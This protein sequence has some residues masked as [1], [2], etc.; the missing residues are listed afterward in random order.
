M[1]P[2]RTRRQHHPLVVEAGHQHVD[3]VADGAEHVLLR[4]LAIRKHQLGGVGAAHAELVELLRGRKTLEALFDDE[5][6]D[7]AGAGG[8]VG[9][10]VDHQRVGE[11]AVGDP[12][13]GAVENVAVALLV[14]AGAHRHHVGA[15][16]RLRHRQ[17]ADVFA[18]DQLG[19]VFALLGLGAVA[20]ELVDAEIG[21]G[22]V[23]QA[24]RRA[25]ARDLF[26]RHAMGEI[27]E[28]RP[29]VLLL[30][31]DAMQAERA[32]LRPQVARKCVAAV[33]LV[34]A[35]GD[36]VLGE[37][38][39][40][41]AQHVHLGAETEVKTSPGIGDHHATPEDAARAASMPHS[42]VLYFAG[43]AVSEA[44]PD[45]SPRS[46]PADR[47]CFSI[48]SIALAGAGLANR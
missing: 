48:R 43:H 26:H 14:G 11:R 10:G 41:L 27:A 13:L 44:A 46:L 5:R 30:D 23:G 21:M 47:P 34:G 29:A 20:A 38:A 40:R 45:A 1:M 12:H 35:G 9:L 39:D 3:A 28:P 19:Q 32:H 4:H 2:K 25:R 6:R 15:R 33:D 16:P 22:A 37:A 8:A 17:R 42:I 31:G 36:L 24:H 7:A 18:R